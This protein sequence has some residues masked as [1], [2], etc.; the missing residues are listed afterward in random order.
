MSGEKVV[1][2]SETGSKDIEE[3]H[4]FIQWKGTN[5]C[6]DFH[7]ECG[8]HHHVDGMFIYAV[9]CEWCGAIYEMPSSVALKRVDSTTA[10]THLC[11]TENLDDDEI[12]ELE[13]ARAEQ[14]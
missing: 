6:M 4:V 10:M 3:P 7:C 14:G 11:K 9:T 5:V 8:A 1:Y 13:A 2:Y 12:A